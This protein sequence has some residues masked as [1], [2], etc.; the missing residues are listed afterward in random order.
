MKT[1]SNIQE[2]TFEF[3]EIETIEDIGYQ[4]CVDIEVEDDHTFCLANGIISHNSAFGGLSSA[5]GRN[6]IGYFA[7]RGVPL[8]AYTAHVSKFVANK[9]LSNLVKIL[10]LSLKKD[11]E[12]NI[13]Y[14]NII[15]AT[16]AD[17]LYENTNILTSEGYKKIKDINHGDKVL[18]HNG[19]YKRVINIIKKD[20]N[21]FTKININDNVIYTTHNHKF[22]VLRDSNIIEICVKDMLPTDKLLIKR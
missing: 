17:C 5:L 8:N 15:I 1:L 18:T 11:A 22:P 7:A 21:V 14:K 4:E 19:Q 13:T 10:G 20:T 12:Q 9:E 2:L 16:D 6:E 3:D